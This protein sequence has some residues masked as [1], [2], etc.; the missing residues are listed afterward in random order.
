MVSMATSQPGNTLIVDKVQHASLQS[1]AVGGAFV[2]EPLRDAATNRFV[3]VFL[4]WPD[5][6]A[7]A[8]DAPLTR[9]ETLNLRHFPYA[10]RCQ[11][12]LEPQATPIEFRIG[13]DVA[14]IPE[15]MPETELFD[16]LRVLV[17]ERI[18][19]PFAAILDWLVWH[20]DRHGA[21]AALIVDRSDS[22]AAVAAALTKAVAA[23][24][25]L[26]SLRRVLIVDIDHPLG[27]PD[28]G[29]ASHPFHLSDAPGK[30]RM[31]QP[32]PDPK[33]SRLGFSLLFDLLRVRYLARARAVA[34]LD[35][36]D[37][38]LLGPQGETLFEALEDQVEAVLNLRGERVYPWSLREGS[39]SFGDHICG[40][41]DGYDRNKSWAA[42]PVR[43]PSGSI[44]MPHRVLG[45]KSEADHA[46]PFW[47]CMAL[48]I[49]DGKVSR[50]VPKT[51]LQEQPDLLDMAAYF[52][53][54]PER[55]P[56]EPI[57]SEH[58]LPARV[59]TGNRTAI[60]TTM[61]NE[62]PFILE[63]L[64]Y[65][66]AIGV[67][68]FLVYT[69][70]CT[71]GTDTFLQLLMA[72]GYVE[73]RENPY[74]TSGMK[75]QH[76]A[77]DAAN[78][79]PLIRDADWVLCMDVDEYIAV[80]VGDG[81]LASLYSAVPDANMI[82]LTWRL[83]GNDDVHEYRDA[84]ITQIFN[85]AAREFAN[86]PHQ[87]WGFKTLFK[88]T[89]AFK[90]LGVHRPK[91]LRP[92]ALNQINWVNGSGKPMPESQWRNAWRS[93]SDTFGYEM[94]S[95]NHYAVRSAESF[96]VK[97]DRGRVNH[98]DRDQGM[99]YWFRMNHNCVPDNRM[100]RVLPLLQ[101]E[102]DRILRDPEIAAA[103]QA[104]VAA[105]RAKIDEL[106]QQPK[107]QEF[108]A[109]LTSPRMQKLARL[110]G[111]FGSNVYLAGP[112]VIPDAILAMDPEDT[113]QFTVEYTDETQH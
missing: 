94:V 86:K 11:I 17:A 71:D 98:V 75:P 19:E 77:L 88:N 51:S 73:W 81:T 41:F 6:A 7:P 85:R 44:W 23:D 28:E 68:D 32:T 16:G 22:P 33:S 89:G 5:S 4:H 39:A 104:C 66:R 14:D 15:V 45:P 99:A 40:R 9:H 43:I 79:E 35:T 76:A 110:H 24:P 8:L 38:A 56:E 42:I 108:Y 55:V 103:H 78:T 111:H 61:K 29:P 21:Q 92:H 25:R 70:D 67:S 84:F 1:W 2:F 54:D 63:W 91:G 37:L 100:Q 53:A 27:R 49:E 47:R 64:A 34:R 90:K 107:Y 112:E 65:H 3:D 80:H 60:V 69:N 109:E 57:Q 93:N 12:K 72:K 87:A 58:L 20:V 96:L 83:F 101:A 106:K 18:N 30:D 31:E 52:G 102:Y 97:R 74:Q 113:F 59:I 95:L 13:A 82:S 10:T 48:R 36:I 46:W 105:H 26:G 62:G 50:I